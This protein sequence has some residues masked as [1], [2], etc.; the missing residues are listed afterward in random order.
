MKTGVARKTGNAS[1]VTTN[2]YRRPIIRTLGQVTLKPHGTGKVDYT[3]ASTLRINEPKAGG[4]KRLVSERKVRMVEHIDKR[5]LQLEPH[6]FVD[7]NTLGNTSVDVEVR[8][9][10]DTIQR[11]IAECAWSRN[12]KNTRLD[13]GTHEPAGRIGRNIQD[14]RI[15]KEYTGRRPE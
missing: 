5:S 11:E 6:A 12:T 10:V 13:R 7:R 1:K 14:R 4:I 3:F 9:S 2:Q 15:D 8:R